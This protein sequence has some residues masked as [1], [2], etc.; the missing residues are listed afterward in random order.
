MSNAFTFLMAILIAGG[1][2]QHVFTCLAAGKW[3]FLIA[4]ALM[5][6]VA[7]LHGW[8]IWLGFG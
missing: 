2:L 7:V 4:G 5:F 3:G 1:W 8:G 6:P